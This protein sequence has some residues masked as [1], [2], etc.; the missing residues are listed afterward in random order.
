MSIFLFSVH[1]YPIALHVGK[2]VDH[3]PEP[4]HHELPQN[5]AEKEP[6]RRPVAPRAR[7]FEH[8]RLDHPGEEN[9][10]PHT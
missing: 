6:A 1:A 5:D 9:A 7:V 4:A 10:E 8:H 2:P 3:Q